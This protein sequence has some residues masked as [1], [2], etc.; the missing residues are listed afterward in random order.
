MFKQLPRSLPIPPR[1]E[2]GKANERRPESGSAG[3]RPSAAAGPGH[4]VFS[5]NSL[6][7]SRKF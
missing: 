6:P 2:E 3:Q 5:V 7:G 1:A 4:T